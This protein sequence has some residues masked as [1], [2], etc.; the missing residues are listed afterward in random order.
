MA[1]ECERSARAYRR[2]PV[3]DVAAHRE[4]RAH[5]AKIAAVV[6]SH[7]VCIANAA[8]ADDF[9]RVS[10]SFCSAVEAL[11]RGQVNELTVLAPEV[12]VISRLSRAVRRF[13]PAAVLVLAAI[14][15]PFLP[16]V[17]NSNAVV[18]SI[19][20]TLIVAGVLALVLPVDSPATARIMDTLTK[21]LAWKDK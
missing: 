7:K 10:A 9:S 15:L 14:A 2:V 17:E 6:R 11:A 1:R 5:F 16:G 12:T 4:L 13:V 19:R 21:S 20:V 18:A 8:K 3:I